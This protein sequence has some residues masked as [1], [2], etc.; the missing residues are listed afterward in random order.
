MEDEDEDED[1]HVNDDGTG[2]TETQTVRPSLQVL[3][4]CASHCTCS[5]SSFPFTYL[6]TAQEKAPDWRKVKHV[7]KCKS[8][9]DLENVL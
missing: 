2:P 7:V 9:V 3:L 5:N 1:D 4:H 6:G 8:Q